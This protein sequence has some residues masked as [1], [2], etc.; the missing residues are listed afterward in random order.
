MDHVLVTNFEGDVCIYRGPTLEEA[1]S[2]AA[3]GEF[4]EYPDVLVA[5]QADPTYS[6]LE[7][8]LGESWTDLYHSGPEAV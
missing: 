4:Q 2:L 7:S 5:W 3:Q 8:L 1:M 6:N